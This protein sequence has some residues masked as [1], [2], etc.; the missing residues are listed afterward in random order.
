M[1][2]RVLLWLALAPLVSIAPATIS[3]QQVKLQTAT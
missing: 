2:A 3:A 1:R